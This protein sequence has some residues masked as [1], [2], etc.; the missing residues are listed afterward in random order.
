[1]RT[2]LHKSKKSEKIP[3]YRV[4]C[5]FGIFVVR[6]SKIII[7]AIRLFILFFRKSG[8]VRTEVV[9]CRLR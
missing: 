6:E 4:F 1:M 8:S 7:Y 9:K 2:V 5:I 3:K